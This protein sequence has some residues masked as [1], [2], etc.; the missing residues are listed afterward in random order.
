MR[1]NVSGKGTRDQY[2]SLRLN[3]AGQKRA[4]RNFLLFP[5]LAPGN[6]EEIDKM[7]KRWSAED[8]RPP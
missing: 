4:D 8:I 5:D 1:P 3:R 2:A 6:R 7:A